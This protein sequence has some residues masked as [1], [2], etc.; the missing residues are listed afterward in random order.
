[1]VKNPV[2]F[3]IK[4]QPP[5]MPGIEWFWTQYQGDEPDKVKIGV[6]RHL[7]AVNGADDFFTVMVFRNQKPSVSH[8]W[9]R[10][11]E[12]AMELAEL[13]NQEHGG[14]LVILDLTDRYIK[15]PSEG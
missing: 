1:M 5:E 2:S 3:E 11:Y 10:S 14:D 13:E 7:P 9:L 12:R 6:F 8:A 15:Y 4:Y